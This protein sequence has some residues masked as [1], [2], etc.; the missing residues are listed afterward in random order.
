LAEEQYLTGFHRL[1][2]P[3]EGEMEGADPGQ[4]SGA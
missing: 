4:V 2:D 1:K 3:G